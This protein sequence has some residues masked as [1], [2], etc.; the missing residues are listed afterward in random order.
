MQKIICWT[1]ALLTISISL[2]LTACGNQADTEGKDK[3]Y[4][5]AADA[6]YA[7]FASVTS[8]NE[9]VGF[10]VDVLKAVA[11]KAGI[12]VQFINTPWEGIFIALDAGDRDIVMSSVTITDERK[13]SMDFSHPYFEAEQLI[14]VVKPSQ[15]NQLSDLKNKKIGVQNATTGDIIMQNLLGKGNTNIK[16]FETMNLAIQEML[17]GG[18]DAVVGD[19]GVINFFIKQNP[20]IL[21]KTVSDPLFTKEFYGYAVKKGNTALLDKLNQ[22]IKAIQKDGILE[23]LHYQY[24]GQNTPI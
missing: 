16:R 19:N 7:P 17:N 14:A 10:D 23:A 6:S 2:L 24:F 15:I 20:D 22:G 5:V 12:K 9:I 11:E 21:L 8:K 18:V 4:L 1:T 13:K 3:V